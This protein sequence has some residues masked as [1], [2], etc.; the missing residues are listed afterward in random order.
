MDNPT[1]NATVRLGASDGTNGYFYALPRPEQ[2]GRIVAKDSWNLKLTLLNDS[3]SSAFDVSTATSTE[4]YVALDDSDLL[5]GTLLANTA[6]IST[7]EITFTCPAGS[8]TNDYARPFTNKGS[9]VIFVRIK[10][11]DST[12]TLRQN[13]NIVTEDMISGND[14]DPTVSS[15]LIQYTPT[16]P[17]DWPDPDPT[18]VSDALDKNASRIYS[19][20][21][22]IKQ[23]KFDAT[24]A[25]AVSNDSSEGYSVGS[26]WIDITGDESYKCID[27]SVGAAA[28]A[29]TSL[30]TDELATVA[31][32][33]NSDDLTEGSTKLLLTTAERSAISA[34]TAK[35]TNATHTGDVTGSTAL[36][37][38]ST[39]ITGKATVTA[40]SGDF[41][42]LSDTSDSGNLKKVDANDFLSASGETNT[43]SNVGSGADVF[44]QKTGVDLEFRG[45]NGSEGI[46]AAVNAD[47]IDLS[48]NTAGLTEE[49]S[50][51]SGDELILWDGVN[52]KRV[53]W[54]NLPGAGGGETNTASNVGSGQDVFKQKT[55]VD[56]EFRGIDGTGLVTAST[57]G[58]NIELNVD[59]ADIAA[60]TDN[61]QTGT[62][63]TLVLTDADNKT[64]WMN[65]ASANTVTIP[66]NASVAFPVGAKI[67]VIQEGAG[68]TTV[69]GDTG[70]TVNGTSGG[71]KAVSA[72]YSGL[73]LS[74]RATDTWI[75]S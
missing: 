45:I 66:T 23:N 29:K 32:S 67:M 70:V 18:L 42:L 63:Y 57:N 33:G 51:A 31:I 55:G 5:S 47:N 38:S 7:N 37:I 30:T 50:P 8:L 35:V 26:V 64:V 75:V 53:D 3:D 2:G 44:K 41:L 68:A 69:T 65:N 19:L 20:E 14:A 49:L 48:L 73:L 74:K 4:M 36:T 15:T 72:Q 27:A 25:P 34:N 71:S 28:W 54:S 52:H 58:D 21:N 6:S 39:A 56:L 60:G 1:F 24:V 62:T 59:P 9:A 11:G 17:A 61:N 10:D 12:I 40:A 16:T 13:I 22:N 43:A 46:T